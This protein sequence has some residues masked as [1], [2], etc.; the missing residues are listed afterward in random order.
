[1]RSHRARAKEADKENEALQSKAKDDDEDENTREDSVS[2]SFEDEMSI[3]DMYQAAFA[4]VSL[5]FQ[6]PVLW[7]KYVKLLS[8]L[9]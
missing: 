7:A 3:R 2:E 9:G 8:S 6:P 4:A 1:M 5:F